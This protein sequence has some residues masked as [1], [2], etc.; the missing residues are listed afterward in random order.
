MKLALLEH[1]APDTPVTRAAT[2]RAPR[3]ARGDRR[4]RRPRPRGRSPTTSRRCSSTPARRAP[5]T[6]WCASSSSPSGCATRAAAP[7][8]PS[9]PTTRSPAT[10]SRSR[11]RSSR[12]SRHSRS[13]RPQ[14]ARPF[15]PRSTPR[16][17]TSSATC[18]TRWCSTPCSRRR[19]TRSRWPT[20]PAAS[21]TSSCAAIRTCSATSWPTESERRHAQLGADQEG[22]EGHDVARRGH[23][24]R[25]P[26]AALH[27]QAVPQGGVGRARR[28][29][30]LDEALDRV[31]TAVAPSARDATTTSRPTSR[32][33]SPPRSSSRGRVASTPNRRCAAGR[34]ATAT[35]SPRWSGWRPRVRLDLAALD[36]AAVA[37]LW[38]EVR[39][40][41]P[42][43]HRRS[44][45]ATYVTSTPSS[46]VA[47]I[48]RSAEV[49][50]GDGA[51]AAGVEV[52]DRLDDLLAGVHHERAV[53]RDR[54]ADR[55]PAE[56]QHLERVE[57]SVLTVGG[58]H[59]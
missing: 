49:D 52:V 54:L 58:A 46:F 14:A 28:P 9:R 16:S 47:Q 44:S 24:A 48:E 2:A 32:S 12:R 33:C 18:S 59:A 17:P 3:R 22:G 25:P 38:L 57:R 7:G 21:T 5:R 27:E 55:K 10:C 50:G 42:T 36:E 30:S 15:P 41:R 29:V 40:R 20:S 8:T 11:T 35:A 51:H 6:R 45:T 43:E 13:T 34:P 23:H 1:L 56:Q 37:A 4:A 26:V 19:P 53:V 31:D 39:L